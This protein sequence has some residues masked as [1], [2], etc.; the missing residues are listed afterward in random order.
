MSEENKVDVE[1]T[2]QMVGEVV[3]GDI[4]AD[5]AGMPLFRAP[6]EITD[7]SKADARTAMLR[8]KLKMAE[9][10][11][12]RRQTKRLSKIFNLLSKVNVLREA[13][14]LPTVTLKQIRGLSGPND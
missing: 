2:P 8:R 14:N 6:V 5:I 11:L 3:I 9:E 7:T 10:K 4:T 12:L 1:P 13:L